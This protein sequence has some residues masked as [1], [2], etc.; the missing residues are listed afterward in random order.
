MVFRPDLY[1]APD[2]PIQML[3]DAD[4]DRADSTNK[5]I[6]NS[7]GAENALQD[8]HHAISAS[9]QGGEP[10][11]APVDQP[12]AAPVDQPAAE[13]MPPELSELTPAQLAVLAGLGSQEIDELIAVVDD[14]VAEDARA[15]GE[16][17]GGEQTDGPTGEPVQMKGPL[18]YVSDAS[19][20]V[21]RGVGHALRP[22]RDPVRNSAVGRFVWGN[23]EDRA[24]RTLVEPMPKMTTQLLKPNA[25]SLVFPIANL[26][27][28]WYS[29]KAILHHWAKRLHPNN[30]DQRVPMPGIRQRLWVGYDPEENGSSALQAAFRPLA[31]PNDI[32]GWPALLD[33]YGPILT[34]GALGAADWRA[35]GGVGHFLIVVGADTAANRIAYK[36]PLNPLDRVTWSDFDHFNPRIDSLAGIDEARARVLLPQLNPHIKLA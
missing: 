29:T 31:K 27:C 36:D 25:L 26:N 3:E 14:V 4:S 11:A 10:A 19:R 24:T 22:V 28:G 6:V 17:S 7:A 15:E 16:Q 2:A 12:A 35:L 34:G 33:T 32:H 13:A 23:Q 18:D 5:V 21:R 30:H 9:K 20:T 8:L 1:A